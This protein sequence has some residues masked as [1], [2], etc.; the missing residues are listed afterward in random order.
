MT[1]KIT[2][3]SGKTYFHR[4]D[5]MITQQTNSMFNVYTYTSQE[6]TRSGELQSTINVST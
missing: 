5:K 1:V 2:T 3:K 6:Q 4:S